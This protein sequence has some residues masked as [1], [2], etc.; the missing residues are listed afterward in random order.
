MAYIGKNLVGVLNEGRTVDTMTGDNSTTTLALS[1]TPG[2]MNNVLVFIDGIRQTPDTDY[3]LSGST[4]TFTTAP[5]TGVSVS[6]ISGNDTPIVPDKGSVSATKL[7]DGSITDSKIVGMSSSKLSGALPALDGSALTGFSSYTVIA[8]DPTITTNPA[9]GVGSLYVNSTSGEFYI[10][11]DATTDNNVWTNVG[12]GSGDVKPLFDISKATLTGVTHD[13]NG[14]NFAA[15]MR[16]IENGTKMFWTNNTATGTFYQLDIPTAW[17]LSSITTSSTEY[18][19]TPSFSVSSQMTMIYKGMA[20]GDNGSKLYINGRNPFGGDNSRK[21]VFMY[22][23]STPY[24][25]TT[26]SYTSLTTNLT[27]GDLTSIEF[28]PNGNVFLMNDTETNDIERW[29]LSTPWDI[30]TDSFAG[31]INNLGG[32]SQLRFTADGM[33]LLEAAISG[34]DKIYQWDLT[35]AWDI[36]TATDSGKFLEL[37]TASINGYSFSE[38]HNKL[39]VTDGSVITEYNLNQ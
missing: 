35:T 27:S 15:D 26:I 3:T 30:T 28:D 10:C 21:H 19:V 12:G 4:L 6:V 25:L 24:D 8:A 32:Q 9:G 36:T 23:L 13:N 31:K 29:N 5:E 18:P 22:T 17:D 37:P 16:V 11:T 39:W 14:L 38:E 20:I 34:T 1:R 33:C 7:V 2:S